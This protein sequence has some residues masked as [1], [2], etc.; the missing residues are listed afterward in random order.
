MHGG[1]VAVYVSEQTGYVGGEEYLFIV[2]DS[3]GRLKSELVKFTHDSTTSAALQI[4]SSSM[5]YPIE[6][7]VYLAFN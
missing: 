2:D 5:A 1:S 6:G 7:H 4:S 3:D